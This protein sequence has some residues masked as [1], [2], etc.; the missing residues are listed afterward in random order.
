[1]DHSDDTIKRSIVKAALYG[2]DKI[3]DIWIEYLGR[4]NREYGRET[5]QNAYLGHN[6]DLCK[7]LLLSPVVDYDE[8]DATLVEIKSDLLPYY[9]KSHKGMIPG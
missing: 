6:F 9:D 4:L 3:I 2:A 7:K 1:M 5:I 8:S